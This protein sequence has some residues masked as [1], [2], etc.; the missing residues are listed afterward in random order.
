MNNEIT[1]HPL[2]VGL[3]RPPMRFGVTLNYLVFNGAM[4]LTV[5][6]ATLSF[7]MATLI[8]LVLQAFGVI[9]CLY[10]ARIFDLLIGKLQCM[11]S[12]NHNYW[13]C[14]SYEPH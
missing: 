11:N 10:D 14:N 7:V 12:K 1:I 6:V 5:F 8:A 3:T 9:C 4:S 13:Q 2:F